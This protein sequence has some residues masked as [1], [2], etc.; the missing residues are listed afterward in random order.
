MVRRARSTVLGF[1]RDCWTAFVLSVHGDDHDWWID[2][3]DP[4]APVIDAMQAS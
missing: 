2:I 3:A 1:G 4:C